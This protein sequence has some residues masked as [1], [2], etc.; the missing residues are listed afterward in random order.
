MEANTNFNF[1][2]LKETPLSLMTELTESNQA[3]TETIPDLTAHTTASPQISPVQQLQAQ[4]GTSLNIGKLVSPKMALQFMDIVFPSMLVLLVSKIFDKVASKKQFQ[5]TAMEK[6]AI[7]EPL[8]NWMNTI[9]LNLNN[10]AEALI[11][12]LVV[13]YGTKVIEVYNEVPAG[14]FKQAKE[15][16]G[17]KTK[18]GYTKQDG[19]GRPPGSK[20]KTKENQPKEDKK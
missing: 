11:L 8:T 7:E 18:E 14:N 20:N 12:A 9:N 16:I 2:T 10:P 13:V 4:Q 15:T 1:Q 3:K 5:L 17:E 6:E 19:R